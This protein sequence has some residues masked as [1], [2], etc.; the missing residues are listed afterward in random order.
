MK[1]IKNMD[2]PWT[3]S[4]DT[5][6]ENWHTLCDWFSKGAG[7]PYQSPIDLSMD[8][9]VANS[10]MKKI[11][12][13]YKKEEFTEK[14]FKNTFHFV[15]PNTESF[16]VFAEEEYFLTDIHF[17]TPSEHSIDGVHQPIEF[18][19][20][21]MNHRGENLVV[22]CFYELTKNPNKFS[23]NTDSYVWKAA[24]H[25]QWFNPSIFLPDN[26]A[27]FHY[28]GSL[29]TPPTKGPVFWFV[30][31]EV[32][33]MDADFFHRMNEGML[34]FNNRPIQK[35]KDRKIYFFK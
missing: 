26:T 35:I 7:Y 9:I 4:G 15:P 33:M 31:T 6:P 1:K 10:D 27:H 29:T 21:H 2:V 28:T 12:F 13:F 20:V 3:Y 34:L 5:G 11:M 32:Q 24:T 19:F 23:Q 16:V 18:H 22:A 17:H 30:F 8:R 25:Q 14:E